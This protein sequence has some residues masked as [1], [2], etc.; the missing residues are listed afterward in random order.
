[1]ARFAR[2][3]QDTAGYPV[4][5]HGNIVSRA[6]RLF[7]LHLGTES[8]LRYVDAPVNVMILQGFRALHL[9]LPLLRC[10]C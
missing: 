3:R 10:S 9:L 8:E 2:D 1:M 4:A 5:A 7:L 6:A